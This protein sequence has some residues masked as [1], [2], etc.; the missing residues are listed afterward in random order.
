MLLFTQRLWTEVG[1]KMKYSNDTGFTLCVLVFGTCIMFLK[2]AV[3]TFYCHSGKGKV[4]RLVA[5]EDQC[6]GLPHQP[7]SLKLS[8][9]MAWKLNFISLMKLQ[10]ALQ[11]LILC[12]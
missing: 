3:E 9:G 11:L 6:G 7:T 5:V 1:Y 12:I 4:S 10:R 8:T 2:A